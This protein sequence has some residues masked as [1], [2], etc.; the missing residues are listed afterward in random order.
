MHVLKAAVFAMF[1]LAQAAPSHADLPGW[2]DT[3]WG[4]SRDDLARSLGDA[5]R[6]LGGR[7]S[8]DGAYA[9]HGVDG[10]AVGGVPF[11]AVFQ[12]AEETD[13][14]VQVLLQPEGK[15]PPESFLRPVH[16]ALRDAL[17]EPA[18]ACVTPGTG[19]GPLSIEILWRFP[20]TTVHLSMFDFRSPAMLSNDP[21]LDP[22]P[23]TPYYETRLNNPRFLPRR[24]LIRYHATADENLMSDCRP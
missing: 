23:L 3:R 17:G 9:T 24:I 8:Y 7:L 21:N 15:Q 10:V 2:G 6:P 5:L 1:L 14:L 16:D 12:M 20:T 4:M 11:R 18:R 22:D 19:G 13:G